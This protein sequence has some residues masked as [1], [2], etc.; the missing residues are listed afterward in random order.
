MASSKLAIADLQPGMTLA[1]PI[2]DNKGRTILPEGTRLTP[3]AINHL[4]KWGVEEVRIRKEQ[5]TTVHKQQAVTGILPESASEK[6]LAFM[7]RVAEDV[8]KRF[9]NLPPTE[10]N[11]ELRRLALKHL[12]TSG[13]GTVPGIGT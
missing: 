8:A 4:G 1:Q 2:L 11:N 6:D 12:I 7:R 13:R 3:M 5:E 10:V 9:A